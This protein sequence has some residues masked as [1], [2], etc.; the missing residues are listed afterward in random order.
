MTKILR[1][2]FVTALPNCRFKEN[3]CQADYR[4][5][6]CADMACALELIIQRLK[7][8]EQINAIKNFFISESKFYKNFG[9]AYKKLEL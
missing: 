2:A 5:L 7:N 1:N 9:K 8:N 4:L 6:Q 3:V